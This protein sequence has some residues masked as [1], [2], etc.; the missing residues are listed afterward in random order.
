MVKNKKLKIAIIKSSDSIRKKYQMLKSDRIDDGLF[1]QKNFKPIIEPLKTLVDNQSKKLFI[2]KEIKTE[3]N[4]K[5]EK[6]EEQEQIE[7]ESEETHN[8]SNSHQYVDDDSFDNQ[9]KSSD[10]SDEFYKTITSETSASENNSFTFNPST[11]IKKV[12]KYDSDMDTTYGVRLVSKNYMIGNSPIQFDEDDIVII[13]NKKYSNTHGLYELLFMKKPNKHIYTQ[14]DLALYKEI[15]LN[16]NLFKRSYLSDTYINGNNSFK[17]TN[18][19]SKLIESEK[20]KNIT[21][22]VS[23][24]GGSVLKKLK[25]YTKNNN[26][27]IRSK[28]LLMKLEVGKPSL[29]YWNDANELVDRLRLL[30]SSQLVGNNSHNNEIIS[31]IEELR[32]ENLIE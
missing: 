2:K 19:I 4:L 25:N 22:N 7:E 10:D 32:E 24:T 17:Y 8:E 26:N 16:T 1:L 6:E 27:N 28:D 21:K 3:K 12:K 18:I 14:D 20:K 13:K 15:G 9:Q 5:K 23:K 29:V 11:Y 30:I 31:I